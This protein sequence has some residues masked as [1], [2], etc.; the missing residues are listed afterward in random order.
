MAK[1]P[2]LTEYYATLGAPAINFG[3]GLL[4][5][6]DPVGTE[7]M[8]NRMTEIEAGRTKGNVGYEDYGLTPVAGRMVG[9]LPELAV[10]NPTDF[11]LA[12]SI[13]KYD[14]SPEGR[15]GLNY[16]FTPDQDTG[17][18]GNA[19]LDYVNSG[20][21]RNSLSN[22]RD[23]FSNMGSAQASEMPVGP[24]SNVERDFPGMSTGDIIDSMQ[25]REYVGKSY[26]RDYLGAGS[27]FLDSKGNEQ[28]GYDTDYNSDP[29]FGDLETNLYGDTSYP[30]EYKTTRLQEFDKY[31][32]IPSLQRALGN[33]RF[34]L[35]PE[36]TS[37]PQELGYVEP[38]AVPKEAIYQD[39]IMNR[40]L[41]NSNY[42]PKQGI[43]QGLQS[44]IGAGFNNVKDFAID[45]G[46]MGKNL[47]GAGAAKFAGLPG[48][49]GSGL[50][51]LLSNLRDP[52]APSYQTRSPNIDYSN[53][54]TNNLNDFYDS[55]EDSDTFG[56]T[57][58][59]RAK[60]GSFGSY[61]TLADYFNRNKTAKLAITKRKAKAEAAAQAAATKAAEAAARG[62]YTPGGSH[63]SRG[64]SGG[65]L[66]LSQA[67]AQSVSQANKDAGYSS[68]SGLK[69]GGLASM[70]TRRR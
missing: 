53:L 18:T 12:G 11:A 49:V 16:D 54:N 10:N 13:G 60:P 2:G 27:P 52:N 3:R 58:F 21:V 30:Q 26:N 4:G 17:S 31:E 55:N 23:S 46:R 20:G 56:T 36:L 32:E 5:Y 67:Q 38:A 69:D 42:E 24:M 33:P 6:Q 14:F 51:S 61:R 29:A 59:D 57:R 15:T 50:M 22:L 41:S 66:G 68:F 19:M 1:L 48:M 64:T 34:A 45:K 7:T 62:N 8:Q 43:L 39:R 44:K 25:D 40:N 9:G 37:Q 65:G 63:L 47:I 28:M 70:F 35:A